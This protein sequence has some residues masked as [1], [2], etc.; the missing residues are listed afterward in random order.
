M[1][2]PL[3]SQAARDRIVKAARRIFGEQGY[4]RTT[5]RAVAAAADIHPSMVMRYYGSKDG[6]FAA[7]AI[8]DLDLPDLSQIAR[9]E[10]GPALVRHFLDRWTASGG[11]LPALLR[12]AVTHEQT[13]D[14]L[15]E[16]MREQIVPRLDAVCEPG[17]ARTRAA[18][19]A[20]QMLGLALTRY[21]LG[22]AYV[23]DLSDDLIV[24]RVGE[25]VQRYLTGAID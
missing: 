1:T 15:S 7:A 19:L 14:R 25:T 4:E 21:I 24:E 6:L 10:I 13:R 8:F 9:D 18:L 5:I 12:I 20:T 11:E 22:L 2:K 17:E 23:A 16:I 3:R